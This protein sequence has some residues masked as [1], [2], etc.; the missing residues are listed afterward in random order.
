MSLTD[1]AI[2]RI[3]TVHPAKGDVVVVSIA[4]HECLDGL[5]RIGDGLRRAF[6]DNQVI[7]L[8]AGADLRTLAAED[9]AVLGL[10]RA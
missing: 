4:E 1:T 7:V 3:E 2:D 10:R 9:L 5:R 8:A 6:P